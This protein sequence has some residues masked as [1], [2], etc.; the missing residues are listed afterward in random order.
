MKTS[1]ERST[2][3]SQLPNINAASSLHLPSKTVEGKSVYSAGQYAIMVSCRCNYTGNVFYKIYLIIGL[4]LSAFLCL[5]FLCYC[6]CSIESRLFFK[7]PTS[8]RPRISRDLVISV[9]SEI[10]GQHGPD[11]GV[12][13]LPVQ[14]KRSFRVEQ[15]VFS[16]HHVLVVL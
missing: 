1:G 8:W 6:L 12:Y 10:S 13:Q 9:A 7:Q 4:F 5:L 11:G 14:V 2:R 3:S 15:H 16:L